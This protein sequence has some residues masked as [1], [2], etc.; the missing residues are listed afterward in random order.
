MLSR[1]NP[2]ALP[3]QPPVWAAGP[4][5]FSAG[6]GTAVVMLH[7]SL[8]S[9]LQWTALGE[10]LSPR[11]RAIALDLCGYGDNAG[12]T[13][14]VPFTLDQEVQLVA[15][16]L[17]GLVKGDARVHLVGH[18]YGALVA[19]RL[20]QCWRDRVASL[21]L[22]EPVAFRLLDEAD[23]GLAHLK[24][25]VARVFRLLAAGRRHEAAQ[26][27]VNFWSGDGSYARLSPSA[28]A[29]LARRVDKLPLDFQAAWGWPANREDLRRIGA[30]TLLLGGRRSPAVVQGIHA[31]L[32]RTLSNRRVGL[33]D[34]GHMGPITD[35]GRVNRWIT[36][37]LHMCE[38]V[39]AARV[40]PP[41][42]F[43][44]L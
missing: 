24:W 17:K 10:R 43:L 42:I 27:F 21:A 25:Y 40:A 32:A 37:F 11:F 44:P 30:P 22:Y 4:G 39:D 9:K 34:S 19:L 41:A 13:G 33:L 29:G 28:Q 3:S 26:V 23:P 38:S 2:R 8:S 16:R 31:L 18:S 14:S 5:Y 6:G 36:A 20:A 7:S 12:I 1:A 35:A 15:D